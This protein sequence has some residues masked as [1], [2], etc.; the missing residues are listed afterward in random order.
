MTKQTGH[1]HNKTGYDH[2]SKHKEAN[3]DVVNFIV[4]LWFYFCDRLF[5]T[6]GLVGVQ[7]TGFSDERRCVF[8]R[9]FR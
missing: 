4:N 1:Q 3:T 2:E 5:D 8:E 6:Q 9:S 7:C